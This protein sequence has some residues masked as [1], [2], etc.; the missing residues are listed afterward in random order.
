MD[1]FRQT[2]RKRERGRLTEIIYKT[3]SYP[4]VAKVAEFY[5]ESKRYLEKGFRALSASIILEIS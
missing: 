1:V 2:I 3:D 5:G 4:I